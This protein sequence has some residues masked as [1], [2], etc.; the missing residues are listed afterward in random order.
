MFEGLADN[1]VSAR[2]RERQRTTATSQ[3]RTSTSETRSSTRRSRGIS[4]SIPK[5]ASFHSQSNSS[6]LT[7]QNPSKFRARYRALV[8]YL[9]VFCFL[10]LYPA[11][12]MYT[13]YR[14]Y[15]AFQFITI[16]SC[17]ESTAHDTLPRLYD[18][19]PNIVPLGSCSIVVAAWSVLA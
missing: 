6:Q 1:V 2:R 10:L 8:S 7:V 17:T 13:I 4:T 5:S 16:V 14:V 19:T 9:S 15:K 12:R 11:T 18:T 3:S